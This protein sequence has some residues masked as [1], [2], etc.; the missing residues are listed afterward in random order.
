MFLWE[1]GF[2]MGYTGHLLCSEIFMTRNSLGDF[3]DITWIVGFGWLV[4]FSD[5]LSY[6]PYGS[7][8]E[9]GHC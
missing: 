5:N 8:K 4:A 7:N 1:Y 6:I 9:C 2:Q 3:N